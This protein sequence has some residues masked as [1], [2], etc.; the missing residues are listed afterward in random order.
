MTRLAPVGAP[1]LLIL[2][3]RDFSPLPDVAE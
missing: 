1:T 3:D 2:G